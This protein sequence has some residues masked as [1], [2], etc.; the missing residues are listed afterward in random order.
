MKQFLSIFF[1]FLS[2]AIYSQEICNNAVDDDNDGLIDIQDPD[3]DCDQ[4]LPS[5]L[6]PNESF[7]DMECCPT[8]EADFQ[9]ATAWQQASAATSDY[10]HTCGI[11]FPS[12]IGHMPP[13]DPIPDGQGYVGFRDGR[14]NDPTYK[15]YVGAC[16]TATMEVGKTYRLDFFLGF[17]GNVNFDHID[18]TIYGTT[19][20]SN[21]PF[22]VPNSNIG[23]PTNTPGWTQMDQLFVSGDNEWKNVVF[24]LIADKPYTAI[25]LGPSCDN[26]PDFPAQPY[27][28]VDRLNL[29]EK[30]DFLL[31]FSEIEGSLC[32]S[33]ITL[34]A[35]NGEDYT[36]QWYKDGIAIP[37]QTSIEFTVNVDM[38]N[39]GE[40]SVVIGT[41]EGCLLSESLD[42]TL[43]ILTEEIEATICEGESYNI[44]GDVLNTGGTYTYDLVSFQ[45]CDSIVTL[46]LEVLQTA[47]TF[48]N[49]ELC[50]GESI[51]IAGEELSESGNY[52]YN[53][54]AANDCDSIINVVLNIEDSPEFTA[55]ATICEGDIY[56]QD[57]DAYSEAGVYPFTYLLPSGCDSTFIL[58]L[59]IAPNYEESIQATICEGESYMFG[60]LE[61]TVSDTYVTNLISS[62][63]CD[64][65]VTLT[66][67]VISSTFSEVSTTICSGE[68]YIL[69]DEEYTEAGSY[70]LITANNEGCDST[71][72][73]TLDVRDHIDQVSLP[74]DT[75]ITLG[76]DLEIIPNYIAPIFDQLVWTNDGGEV[77]SNENSV[78][79]PIVT[80]PDIITLLAVDELGCVDEDEIQIRV[81]RN[82][83]IFAPNI[84]SPNSDGNNDFFKPKTN[85]SIESLK[86]MLVYDRWGNLVYQNNNV[87]DLESWLGWDGNFKNE[88][89]EQ[90]VYVYI[91]TF[92]ALDGVE[93]V[94]SGDVTLIR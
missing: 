79:L 82:I 42:L 77:L 85:S 15:E 45:G 93:E 86:E 47:T 65:S 60:G 8:G 92:V 89:A 68:S 59:S 22:G 3:C 16:L 91:A 39:E 69:D 87:A 18:M 11:T 48:I 81:D 23:C 74:N 72:L 70:Q 10:Y 57:G 53:L 33:Q 37:G 63:G 1:I 25:I 34:T 73:L 88:K 20:C 56:I 90:G 78:Y 62:F 7:E 31:P 94:I 52:F 36:Y 66:L 12:W 29:V 27:F 55:N 40:Y 76:D 71:I 19:E 50:E 5:G 38:I 13:S 80:M 75:L 51:F 83:G 84:F 9:C 58:D 61:R 14:A 28:F 35:E 43:P 26:H 24:D 6:I 49:E 17:P 46:D 21:I 4:V 41:P 54:T 32:E 44:A 67:E 2:L 30:V 64:S